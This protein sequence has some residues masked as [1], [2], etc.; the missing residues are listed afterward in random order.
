MILC[1]FLSDTS[2]M[3]LCRQITYTRLTLIQ[4]GRQGKVTISLSLRTWG[5]FYFFRSFNTWSHK[6]QDI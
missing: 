6:K 5:R 4:N 2:S 3:L 1:H